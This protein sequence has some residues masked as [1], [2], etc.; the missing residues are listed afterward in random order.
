MLKSLSLLERLGLVLRGEA[1]NEELPRRT[2]VR[3]G[4]TERPGDGL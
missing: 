4:A 3:P 2:G 1:S